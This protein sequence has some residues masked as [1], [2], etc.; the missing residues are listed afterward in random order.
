MSGVEGINYLGNQIEIYN[1]DRFIICVIDH[2]RRRTTF[3][4]SISQEAYES[5]LRWV[6]ETVRW[7]DETVESRNPS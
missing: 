7:V 5:G 3:H 1:E 4:T 2:W 6:D